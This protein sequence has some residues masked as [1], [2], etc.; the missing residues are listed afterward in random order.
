VPQS[1]W[2]GKIR[3]QDKVE[4][5]INP[6]SPLNKQAGRVLRLEETL[7]ITDTGGEFYFKYPNQLET[8]SDGSF[9]VADVGELLKFT[10]DGRFVKNL[11]KKG[12]GPGE[13][14]QFY[15]FSLQDSGEI[16]AFDRG[17]M[18]AV[19]QD[20]EGH[21]LEETKLP[22][23]FGSCE[24]MTDHW[25]VFYKFFRTPPKDQTF[26]LNDRKNVLTWVPRKGKAKE[27]SHIFLNKIF[28]GPGFAMT[29]DE[30]RW[31]LDRE[32]ECIFFS[33]TR[34]YQVELLDLNKGS[35][36]RSFKRD[37]P[38]VKYVMKERDEEIYKK[39]HPPEK[40][41]ESDI[42]NLFISE[43]KLWVQTST[44]DK[45]KGFLIDVFNDEGKYLD[46]FYLPIK[47][48]ILAL[49]GDSVFIIEKDENELV[50]IAQYRLIGL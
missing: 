25:L 5:V 39:Y 15:R 43:G 28:G 50:Q 18:K 1:E 10:K 19:R 33:C 46:N 20:L 44:E 45:K 13:F 34:E 24:G 40:K 9:F 30:V 32:R 22:D 23:S 12:Q 38:R 2:K 21:L 35:I 8:A 27:R 31:A 14:E 41:Y 4:I 11:I 17:R 3:Y 37:Y 29:W 7:R 48:S 26:T 42:L 6:K 36:V 49:Q 16:C 47:G